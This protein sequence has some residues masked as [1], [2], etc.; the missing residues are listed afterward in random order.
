MADTVYLSIVI[1]AYNE[2]ARMGA[3][4]KAIRAYLKAQ[5]YSAEII[6]END[7]SKDETSQVAQDGLRGM[8]HALYDHPENQGK[9]AVV[10]HGI[11]KARGQYILFTD[12]D[13]STPIEEIGGFLQLLQS[14]YDVVIGSRAL[15]TSRVEVRQ[16]IIR[17]SMGKIFN[18]LAR[19]LSFKD[20]HDSQ[21]GF[22]CFRREA[23]RDLF[24]RQV[25]MDFSFDAEII[26]LAQ[27]LDYKV[28]EA[29]VNW[30]NSPNSRVSILK[31]SASMFLNLLR[32]KKL[33][34]NEPPRGYFK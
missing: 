26:Y 5:S 21:C 28:I 14:G 16:N 24:S 11:L 20:I 4:L 6:I 3:T 34:R 27:L 19:F 32:I 10:K 12:A 33:H 9:G 31:D 17:Q 8:E 29:P 1:P 22:K 7:G 30:K 2:S 25:L 23:A 18:R 13:L 15:E